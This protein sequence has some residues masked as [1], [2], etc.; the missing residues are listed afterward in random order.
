MLDTKMYGE[1]LILIEVEPIK[2]KKQI[3]AMKK[4]LKGGNIRNYCLFVL[5]VNIGLRVSDL[6]NLRVKDVVD[7]YR[8]KEYITVKERKTSKT[9]VFSINKNA[10]QAIQD[11]VSCY[12]K[13]DPNSFLFKSRQGVNKPIT[14]VQ[15]WQILNDAANGIG[16]NQKIGTHTLKKTFGY[17][18]Y[19]QGIDIT[20]LQK[21]FNHSSPAI[22]LRYIGITQ[23]DINEVYINLN[24]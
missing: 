1:G 3:E 13:P 12:R 17:W 23:E 19:K 4:I 22:T 24:L 16:L 20:L 21:I 8:V 14:R 11:L 2:N 7:N 9:R 10:K 5:G 18:A 6:L 15:A